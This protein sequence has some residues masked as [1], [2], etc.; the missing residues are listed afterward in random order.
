MIS[1][2]GFPI[3]TFVPSADHFF[4]LIHPDD[5][6]MVKRQIRAHIE[7][8]VPFRI[9]FRIRHADGH[10]ITTRA[11]GTVIS[12]SEGKTSEMIGVTFDVTEEMETIEKLRN[13]EA[14]IE[15]LTSNFDGALFRYRLNANGTD[16][17]DYMS[18]GAERVWGLKASQIVGDPG[19][20]W[21]T[22]HP[23]DVAGVEAA[24]ATGTS[25]QTRLHHQWR[26]ILPDGY[27]RWI[28]CRAVPTKLPSGD[29]IWDGFVIDI[30]DLVAAKDE[31]RE[32]TQ[33]LGQA[34]KLEAIGRISGGIAHDFN[35]LLAI[36][37]GNAELIDA[38]SL[39]IEDQDSQKAIIAACQKGASLTRRLLSFAR[40]SRLE[41][42]I[43]LLRDVV[44]GMMP[45]VRRTLPTDIVVH[46]NIYD[47]R[48]L[49]VAVDVGMLESSIL[50]MILNARDS[51][52]NGGELSINIIER[53]FAE[54]QTNRNSGI[55]TAGNYAVM[56]IIDNG[57][58]IPADLLEKVTEPFVTTKGP[59]MGSGLGLA[60]VDGFVAQS[61]GILRIESTV[62]AGTIL[63]VLLPIIDLEAAE[64][65]KSKQSEADQKLLKGRVLLVEDE[66]EVRLVL[67]RVLRRLGLQVD[68]AQN[69][70]DAKAILK[71]GER[72]FD[73][74]ITDVVMP[75]PVN[76]I[77]LARY[78]QVSHPTLP[79]ILISGYNDQKFTDRGDEA[80]LGIF[81]VKPVDSYNLRDAV[82]RSITRKRG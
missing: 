78:V 37:L 18:D 32:K 46:W 71:R 70:E 79:I 54:S 12:K 61:G 42:K 82:L 8:G 81:L 26:V 58:G 52:P 30:S 50:N 38:G 33:M 27:N 55:V 10:Y 34:Q 1:I 57:H 21:S 44:A 73:L 19:K 5:Y 6:L 13:C 29:T 40:K 31:L 67:S 28:E 3:G 7:Q 14:R 36:I 66:E 17:I 16:S 80:D 69:G 43:V 4:E 11:E 45:L 35:N 60:M 77:D 56:E 2:H 15:T 9:V 23:E 22:V 51:M 63:K 75:G 20:V 59:E 76:G 62:G 47:C 24:F 64:V 25:A 65:L 68:G 39:S 48:D 53:Y 41:P 74:L 49:A 72:Q